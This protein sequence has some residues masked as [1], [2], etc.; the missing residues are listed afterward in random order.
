MSLALFLFA[1]APEEAI[2][3][4]GRGLPD[5][6]PGQHRLVKDRADLDRAASARMEEV[7]RS[8]AG[9][10]SFRRSDAR[11]SH[12]TGHPVT[13]GEG[14]PSARPARRPPVEPVLLPRRGH[15]RI[16]AVRLYF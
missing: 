5:E 16:G 1:A 4:T 10:T 9:L 3:I 8:V 14:L 15:P 7:V 12:P 6:P 11:S 2:V 13:P